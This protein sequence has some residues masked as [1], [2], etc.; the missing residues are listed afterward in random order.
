M[1][2]EQLVCLLAGTATDVSFIQLN[3]T[4]SLKPQGIW[5][6]RIGEKVRRLKGQV[7]T[8][9]GVYR[10]G[11]TVHFKGLVREYQEGRIVS[12]QGDV[13]SFEVTSPKGEKVFS[14]EETLSDFGGA[15][16]DADRRR[17]L[18]PGDLHPDHVVWPQ[19]AGV[20]GRV[21]RTAGALR[22]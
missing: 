2:H 3:P 6:V 4:D 10:P 18:A 15:A 19:A 11:E 7:F 20:P 9:R 1:T 8:E 5:Q 13:C 12:P 17:P 21:Q 14:G 22:R 16:G